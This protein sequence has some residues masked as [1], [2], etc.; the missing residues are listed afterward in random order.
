[1]ETSIYR[2]VRRYYNETVIQDMRSMVV[3]YL[4]SRWTKG[5]VGIDLSGPL[6]FCSTRL[7]SSWCFVKKERGGAG[8]K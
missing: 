8:N 2:V 7:N 3:K 1:M 4:Q 6:F 5:Y